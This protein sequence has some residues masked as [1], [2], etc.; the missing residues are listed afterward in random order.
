MAK[1]TDKDKYV[2]QRDLEAFGEKLH[3]SIV[4]DI[5]GVIQT[6][7]DRVDERFNRLEARAD[8]LEED[9]GRLQNTLDAFL[10]RLDDIEKDNAARDIQLARFER[11]IQQIADKT[12]VKL[13][14][15]Q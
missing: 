11:W 14:Y 10:K 2:T 6:F 1:V 13:D 9:F 5:S 4:D 15:Y 3:K 12:G 7:S 8:K